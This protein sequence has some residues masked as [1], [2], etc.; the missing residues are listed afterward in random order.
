MLRVNE[1]E[2]LTNNILSFISNSYKEKGIHYM[3]TKSS[4]GYAFHT[5]KSSNNFRFKVIEDN[6]TAI[7]T[8]SFGIDWKYYTEEE[9]FT[10]IKTLL[11][12]ENK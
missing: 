12:K 9:V 10:I 5:L 3:I 7:N 4:N 6:V 11:D 8:K 1:Q 2:T